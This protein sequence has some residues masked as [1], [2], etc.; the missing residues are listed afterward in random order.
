MEQLT[1]GT[2]KMFLAR[3][4]A[5]REDP[6]KYVDSYRTMCVLP[7]VF[8]LKCFHIFIPE[9]RI[10]SASWFQTGRNKSIKA[11]K[12][13]KKKPKTTKKEGEV[14]VVWQQQNPP[15]IKK[16]TRKTIKK[17]TNMEDSCCLCYLAYVLLLSTVYI[18]AFTDTKLAFLVFSD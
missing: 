16:Q 15:N 2:A 7:L 3:T 17:K 13:K 12:K 9:N 14:V 5:S 11:S 6:K 10:S 4:A 18:L 1:T 8:F